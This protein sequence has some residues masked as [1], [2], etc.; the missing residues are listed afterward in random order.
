MRPENPYR[1]FHLAALEK[2]GKLPLNHEQLETILS[3]RVQAGNTLIGAMVEAGKSNPALHCGRVVWLG[4]DQHVFEAGIRHLDALVEN[5]NPQ[6]KDYFDPKGASGLHNQ[7]LRSIQ[8][9]V[10]SLDPG[11]I[12]IAPAV[13][14]DIVDEI[15]ADATIPEGVELYRFGYCER[16]GKTKADNQFALDFNERGQPSSRAE[17][18]DYYLERI[19]S[20]SDNTPAKIAIRKE[21][22]EQ[23]ALVQQLTEE[24]MQ[25]IH[26]R[27]NHWPVTFAFCPKIIEIEEEK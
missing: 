24:E 10:L 9:L 27:G 4:G 14:A 23:L 18:I 5:T 12:N 3:L 19:G 2:A 1:D 22:E 25:F 17:M 26:S 8:F 7:L 6:I 11:L 21:L 15:V 16:W 13:I 20:Y